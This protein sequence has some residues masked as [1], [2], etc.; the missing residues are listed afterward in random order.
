MNAARRCAVLVPVGREPEPD[1]E[2]SLREL[3]RRGYPVIRARG[4]AQIDYL[5]SQMASDFLGEGFDETMWIDSD[6]GFTADDVDK[7][8]SHQL[9]IACGLYARKGA[10]AIAAKC[11]PGTA[12]LSFGLA[13]GLVEIMYAGTGFLHIRREVYEAVERKFNLPTCNVGTGRQLVPFFL[14][15]VAPIDGEPFYLSEDYS[16]CE[17]A[18]QAGFKIMADTSIRLWH[19][20]SYRYGWEDAARPPMR[21]DAFVYSISPASQGLPP[22]ATG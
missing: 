15:M 4:G 22:A 17:R 2:S 20:G 3:E 21:H 1:C 18:R 5:R 7:V 16:F 10:L 11:L 13:G 6:I 12:S 19:I 14:P 8:R 9:P